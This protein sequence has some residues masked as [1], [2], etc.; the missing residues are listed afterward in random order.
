MRSMPPPASA[1]VPV[2]VVLPLGALA[3]FIASVGCM[4]QEA[5]ES[6]QTATPTDAVFADDFSDPASGWPVADG[7]AGPQTRYVDGAYEVTAP[8]GQTALVSPAPQRPSS[9]GIAFSVDATRQVDASAHGGGWGLVC[10]QDLEAD[11][12]YQGLIQVSPGEARVGLFRWENGDVEAFQKFATS[13]A[14]V[15]DDV[16]RLELGCTE[17]SE[18]VTVVFSVNGTG[19]AR[20]VDDDGPRGE[21]WLSGLYLDGSPLLAEERITIRFDNYEATGGA[22]LE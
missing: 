17:G 16:N 21:H 20:A 8:A 10:G 3:L 22:A 12:F 5:G 4:P 9:G 1:L 13:G 14:V 15:V 11:G 18:G 7:Q 19:V 2:R 6:D